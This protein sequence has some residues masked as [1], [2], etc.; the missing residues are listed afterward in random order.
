MNELEANKTFTDEFMSLTSEARRA[1]LSERRPVPVEVRVSKETKPTRISNA[2][3][4]K[5]V[6]LKESKVLRTFLDKRLTN[7]AV[8]KPAARA[9][10]VLSSRPAIAQDRSR[11]FTET[12]NEERGNLFFTP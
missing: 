2:A 11:F 1:K 5:E 3:V 7:K 12:I 6:K 10:V 9:T 8:V 4:K